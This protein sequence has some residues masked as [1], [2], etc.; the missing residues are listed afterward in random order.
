M[1][2][3]M[4]I[5]SYKDVNIKKELIE[6]HRD[7][8]E[9]IFVK[10]GHLLFEEDNPMPGIYFC[11]SGILR[12]YSTVKKMDGTKAG[13]AIIK[14]IKEI[15][16]RFYSE[17]EMMIPFA[18]LLKGAPMTLNLQV[19]EAGWFYFI[20]MEDLAILI[21]REPDLFRDML[22]KI[23][24]ETFAYVSDYQYS[25]SNNNIRIILIPNASLRIISFSFSTI[26]GDSPALSIFCT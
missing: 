9:R 13:K 24:M 15:T 18:S 3:Q 12:A 23:A 20:S 1:K 16:N 5:Y 7:L 8:N 10:K 25:N 6:Q 4:M 21:K 2:E 19:I 14:K 26:T 11:E 17:N 22:F